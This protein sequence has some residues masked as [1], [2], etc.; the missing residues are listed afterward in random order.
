MTRPKAPGAGLGLHQAFSF[1]PLTDAP[2]SGSKSTARAYLC[3][4]VCPHGMKPAVPATVGI[5]CP[6]R[7][8]LLS[9]RGGRG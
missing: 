5:L 3:C 1:L 2:D 7:L 8:Q 6:R 4:V 9:E